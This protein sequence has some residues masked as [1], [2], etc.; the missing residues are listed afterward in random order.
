MRAGHSR[1]ARVHRTTTTATLLVTVAV[2]AVSGCV[3]VQ[4]PPSPGVPAPPGKPSASHADVRAEPHIVQAPA[5][6]ALE[7][8]GPPHRPAPP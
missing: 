6:E 1:V 3:T 2:S 5:R 7:H 8:V 4:H